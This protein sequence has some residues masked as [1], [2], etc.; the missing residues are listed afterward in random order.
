MN[1]LG[2]AA[3]RVSVSF[4]TA[5]VLLI[6]LFLLTLFG[7]LEQEWVRQLDRLWDNTEHARRDLP[8]YIHGF[9]NPSRRHSTLAYPSPGSCMSP[10][11][12]S[13]FGG[14][15]LLAA[16]VGCAQNG[17]KTTAW[18]W[19]TPRDPKPTNP[20]YVDGPSKRSKVIYVDGPSKRSKVIP[21]CW[22]R[23]PALHLQH[24]GLPTELLVASAHAFDLAPPLSAD[25]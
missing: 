25:K 7:T 5:C 9:Y 3:W 4:G 24:H 19:R 12:T 21:R 8:Q 13:E 6:C 20:T 2:K 11:F 18:G 10:L 1:D 15:L 22:A 14:S 17:P 23:R 16:G